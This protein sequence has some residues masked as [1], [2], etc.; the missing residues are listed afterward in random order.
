[1]PLTASHD[2]LVILLYRSGNF[3]MVRSRAPQYVSH[4]G[5]G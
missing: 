5:S 3:G 2:A 1:M 4:C